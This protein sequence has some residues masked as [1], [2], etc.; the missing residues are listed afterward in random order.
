MRAEMRTPE[1]VCAELMSLESKVAGLNKAYDCA[2]DGSQA[3][4]DAVAAIDSAIKRRNALE[5]EINAILGD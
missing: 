3:K 4:R 2:A 5:D 1:E